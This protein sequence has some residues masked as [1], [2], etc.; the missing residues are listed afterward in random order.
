M[1]TPHQSRRRAMITILAGLALST[2]SCS[3]GPSD[4]ATPPTIPSLASY[5]LTGLDAPQVIE[6]LDTMLAADRP[7]DLLASVQPTELIVSSSAQSLTLTMPDETFYLS[8][9]PYLT[10]THPCQFH[11]LTTC[12]GELD[13]AQVHVT[14]TDTATGN[15]LINE[16]RTTY[17]NG[18]LGLWLPRDISAHLTID[19]GDKSATATI[20]TG[21]QDPTCLTTMKL[22]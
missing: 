3:T 16:P 13:N 18:F 8:V 14:V 19:H 7:S 2:A 1:T 21:V 20:S 17:D 5:G 4:S 9:A 15:T 11:S 12:Q 6:K 10:T 22:T